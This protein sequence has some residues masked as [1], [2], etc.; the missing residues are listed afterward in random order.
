MQQAQGYNNLYPICAKAFTWPNKVTLP[1]GWGEETEQMTGILARWAQHELKTSKL[2]VNTDHSNSNFPS[3]PSQELR[4]L[5]YGAECAAE[6]GCSSQGIPFA[7]S[8]LQLWLQA[9]THTLLSTPQVARRSQLARSSLPHHTP[10]SA[11]ILCLWDQ[12]APAIG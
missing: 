1:T 2:L 11:E 8:R 4:A 12:G 7:K 9:R 10:G 5:R 6:V 3:H